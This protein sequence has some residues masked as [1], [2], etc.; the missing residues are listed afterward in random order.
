MR[1]L[2]SRGRSLSFRSSG[3]YSHSSH[4]RRNSPSMTKSGPARADFATGPRHV[5][6]SEVRYHDSDQIPQGALSVKWCTGPEHKTDNP[7]KERCRNGR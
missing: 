6:T 3:G 5:S 7:D 1:S 4:Q 2:C